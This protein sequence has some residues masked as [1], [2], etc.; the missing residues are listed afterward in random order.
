MEALQ[1]IMLAVLV[2]GVGAI[3]ALLLS[4]QPRAARITAGTSG[5]LGSLVALSAA[6]QAALRAPATLALETGLPFGPLTLRLDGLST[7][8]VAAIALIALASSVYSIAYLGQ[9]SQR[10]LG[11]LGFFFNLFI[12]LML[13]VVVVANAF[14]FLLVWEMM[15]LASYFLVTFESEKAESIQAGFL[16]MLVAHAGTALI[17][18]AFLIFYAGAGSFDFAAMRQAPLPPAARHTVFLLL[19]FG[20]GAKSGLVPL[21]IWLPRAHP[22]APSPASALLSGVMIKTA[23]YGL[24]RVGVDLLGDAA[25]W[26]GLL[27]LLFGVASALLGVFYALAERDLKRLLAYSSVENV[28]IILAGVGVG[29]I[30]VA[31]QRP[32]V[33]L[34]GFLAALYHLLS[35]ACFKGLLFLGAGALDYRLHDRN[36]NAMG[37]LA[38]RM[39]V[40]ALLFLVGA[41]AVAAVPPLNGF[42][43]EWLIYQSF[44]AGS[45]APEFVVRAALPLSAGVLALVGALAAMVAIKAYGSAFAGPARTARCAQASEVPSVMLA[46]MLILALACAALGLGAPL[47]APYLASVV[48]QALHVPAQAAGGSPWA[49]PVQT[50]GAVLAPALVALLLL[51]LLSVPLGLVV[52]YR[53]FRAGQRVVADPWA[54]GY[55]YSSP[56]SVSAS[57]FERPLAAAFGGVYWLRSM[58]LRPLAAVAAWSGRAR[59]GLGRAEPW[60][61]QALGQPA[62]RAVDYLA[63][64]IQALQM[65]DVRV[66]CL[67][68][69]LTLAVLL[70]VTVVR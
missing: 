56:M 8:M 45:R 68:I 13:L 33:A 36:L 54:C 43:S 15:T 23:V 19:F 55:G 64:H 48:T 32:A 53:G 70:L 49:Y 35:H 67:Y 57:N 69:V 62:T 9:Y 34:L 65:G 6:A 38:R 16:Y 28:G 41:L 63:R 17:T 51:G 50:S 20:F 29:M 59:D 2:Y 3:A 26:W 60:L 7:V 52:V 18:L 27:V 31:V 14:Y 25:L 21:H 10:N 42:V 66:Y 61:E 4:R 58:T 30:G 11:G 24:L 1:L 39:P 12:S 5:A 44:F 37:G 22:A 46:G 47:V 40:T